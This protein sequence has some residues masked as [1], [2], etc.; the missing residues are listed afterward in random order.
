[1]EAIF[2]NHENILNVLQL[3]QQFFMIKTIFIFIMA[4][5]F[6]PTGSSSGDKMYKYK[7]VVGQ[8]IMGFFTAVICT[9]VYIHFCF[10]CVIV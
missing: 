8:N 10:T 1:M 9:H 6:N 3:I 2:V 4:A 7:M 5:C